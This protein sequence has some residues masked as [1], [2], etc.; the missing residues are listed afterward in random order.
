MV[1]KMKLKRSIRKNTKKGKNMILA[2]LSKKKNKE[3][4]SKKIFKPK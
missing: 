2:K 4:R 3:K 1:K